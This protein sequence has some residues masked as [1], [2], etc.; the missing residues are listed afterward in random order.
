LLTGARPAPGELAQCRV[1]DFRADL[2]VLTIKHSKT[3]ERD[4][5]L[6]AEAVG[7]FETIAAGKAPDDLLLP[8]DDGASGWGYNHQS[9]PMRAAVARAKLSRDTCMYSLRHTYASQSILAG[10]N[11][12]L[13][14]DNMGTSIKMLETHYGKFIAASRRKLI[15]ESAFKLGLPESNVATMR[16]R[17]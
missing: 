1:R 9:K 7:F 14:A 2:H 3:G 15:E 8:K 11:L 13:L 4:V 16:Q 12:K 10:M 5:V 17:P 6:T